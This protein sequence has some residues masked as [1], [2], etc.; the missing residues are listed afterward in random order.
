MPKIIHFI[1]AGGPK[2]FPNDSV[3]QAWREKNPDCQ[4]ILWVDKSTTSSSV[5]QQYKSKLHYQECGKEGPSLGTVLATRASPTESPPDMPLVVFEDIAK[6][7]EDAR[8]VLPKKLVEQAEACIRYEI[9]RF[10]PNYGASSDILRYLI[11]TTYGGAYFDSDV[12]VGKHPIPLNHFGENTY[13][14]TGKTQGVLRVGNDAFVCSPGHQHM[15]GILKYA[16]KSYQDEMFNN[17]DKYDVVSYVA[18]M[19]PSKTGPDLV[20]TYMNEHMGVSYV[21][22]LPPKECRLSTK[23]YTPTSANDRNW[24]GV[25]IKSCL[26]INDSLQVA[27]KSLRFECHTIGI[28]RMA[29]HIRDII[30]SLQQPMIASLKL[31]ISK[32]IIN[33]FAEESLDLPVALKHAFIK[34][35]GINID[36]ELLLRA[37]KAI[38]EKY[39]KQQDKAV[40]V[41]H[42]LNFILKEKPFNNNLSLLVNALN[43][44]YQLQPL[45]EIQPL[46]N[47]VMMLRS[48]FETVGISLLKEKKIEKLNFMDCCSILNELQPNRYGF[49]EVES[50]IG[51]C[52]ALRMLDIS[53]LET[54]KL[55]LLDK[56]DKFSQ[57]FVK[58]LHSIQNSPEHHEYIHIVN[59]VND[60][61]TRIDMC[62]LRSNKNSDA[63]Q[64]LQDVKQDACKVQLMLLNTIKW[65]NECDKSPSN[66]VELKCRMHEI[67]AQAIDMEASY[68]RGRLKMGEYDSKIPGLLFALRDSAKEERMAAFWKRAENEN[69]PQY[70]Y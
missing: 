46:Y 11:L 34:T 17:P 55:S 27:Q 28:L 39:P 48:E 5:F 25:P 35:F 32:I 41:D 19:T 58:L 37:I 14:V 31:Q 61:L 68:Q 33:N 54:T 45:I 6:L 63:Y 9:E 22:K 67:K 43:G 13:K 21:K 56:N 40:L 62:F 24:I 8:K 70:K 2:P 1:W 47:Y 44:I 12:L 52:L 3:I 59:T 18:T 49:S 57:P 53:I 38:T 16:L 65:W 60:C 64:A 10:H 66:Q 50:R 23:C 69:N 7:F 36:E 30:E 15:V 4:I 51:E 26:F 42:V 29:A 20:L